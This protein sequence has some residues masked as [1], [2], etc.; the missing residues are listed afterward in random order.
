M[1]ERAIPVVDLSKFVD[2]DEKQRAEFVHEIGKAFHEVGFVGVRNH[3]VPQELVDNFYTASKE[4]FSL[5][6]AQKRAYEIPGLAGQR[7]YTA[8]GTEKAKQSEVADLKE[9]YQIGQVN[10]NEEKLI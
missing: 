4:F 1:A 2:G 8:F 5:P 9:F 10:E 6:V 3:G 7:G